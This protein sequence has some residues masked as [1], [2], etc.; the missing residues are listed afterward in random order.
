MNLPLVLVEVRGVAYMCRKSSRESV[1]SVA[2]N[3]CCAQKSV[4][5]HYFLQAQR[6]VTQTNQGNSRKELGKLH[7]CSRIKLFQETTCNSCSGM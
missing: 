4:V 5:Q 6:H 2:A 1:E 7:P 3:E